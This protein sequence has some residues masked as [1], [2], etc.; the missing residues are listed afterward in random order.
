MI[1]GGK[2]DRD[3]L[4]VEP[5]QM[6]ACLSYFCHR[7]CFYHSSFLPAV[8]QTSAQISVESLW[9]STRSQSFAFGYLSHPV[10]QNEKLPPFFALVSCDSNPLQ[11]KYVFDLTIA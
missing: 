10:V 8:S 4:Q 9:Q 11:E 2:D 7:S 6:Q 1:R 3:L 5:V